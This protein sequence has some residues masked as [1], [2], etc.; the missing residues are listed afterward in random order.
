MTI[1]AGLCRLICPM[2]GAQEMHPDGDKLLIRAY[3]VDNYSQCLACSG[4]YLMIDGEYLET[5]NLHNP[6]KGWFK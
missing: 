4:Y 1:V 5:P 2:C 6:K 3:K